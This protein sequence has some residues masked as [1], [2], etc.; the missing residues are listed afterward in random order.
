MNLE[1]NIQKRFI[2]IVT[3]K[4]DVTLPSSAH[5][6]YANLIFYR[7]K[8]VFSKSFPRFIKLIDDD[9]LSELI[10]NFIKE[11]AKDPILWKANEE[12]KNF[13]LA[14]NSLNILHLE[15]LLNF[16]Y[17]ETQMYMND[18]SKESRAEFSLQKN[19]SLSESSKLITLNYPVHHP[20][21]DKNSV[22]F[23]KGDYFLIVYYKEESNEIIYEEITP[24]INDFFL[25]LTNEQT[26]EFHLQTI[27]HKYE[28]SLE[29]I[30][31]VFHET[32]KSYVKNKILVN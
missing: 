15:D 12:F 1:Q 10:Y 30:L 14:H 9:T 28:V 20:D 32:L 18:F 27:A 26:L 5:R 25:T 19:Y 21:F 16:E 11:G 31:E 13:L 17:L 6:V 29:D 2:E 22:D 3:N 8:D 23:E 4:V 24:F 7:L